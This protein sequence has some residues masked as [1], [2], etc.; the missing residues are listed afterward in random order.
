[1]KFIYIPIVF[2]ALFFFPFSLVDTTTYSPP[3]KSFQDFKQYYKFVNLAN[4]QIYYGKIGSADLYLDSAFNQVAIPFL[5]DLQKKV[6]INWKFKKHKENIKLL[7]FIMKEKHMTP[8][9]LAL[10]F[11]KD[12][13]DHYKLVSIPD[14]MSPKMAA[15]KKE[16]ELIFMSHQKRVGGFDL[17]GNKNTDNNEKSD[18]IVKK[19]RREFYQL[20]QAKQFVDMI[21][22]YGF[23]SENQ[24]GYFINKNSNE[25]EE[26]YTSLST[27]LDVLII[28]F[29]NTKFRDK[30]C[31]ILDQALK[32]NKI[33]PAVYAH[34]IDRSHGRLEVEDYEFFYIEPAIIEVM[35][36][37]YKPFIEYNKELVGK[38]NA[39][40]IQIGL[41]S[42]HTE[43]YQMATMKICADSLYKD[44]IPIPSYSYIDQYGLGVVMYGFNNDKEKL[45]EFRID[46]DKVRSQCNCKELSY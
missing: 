13:M 7:N 20:Y 37:F 27:A 9:Q 34:I 44:L 5:K 45:K 21:H 29:L 3:K 39:N 36:T 30:L 43:Q 40:R 32:D 41:D 23:P 12:I 16:L 22:K 35:G 42:L 46:I 17:H 10:L 4:R 26:K 24:I 11:R 2:I 6:I 1:M 33:H 15:L 25:D 19:Q 14:K 18:A 31:S 28:D 8:E 38:F